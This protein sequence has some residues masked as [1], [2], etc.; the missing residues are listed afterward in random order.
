MCIMKS[1]KLTSISHLTLQDLRAI[2]Q[3]SNLND[4]EASAL[5]NQIRQI[6]NVIHNFIKTKSYD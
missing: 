6:S 5:L 2:K 4:H 3:Y 1:G